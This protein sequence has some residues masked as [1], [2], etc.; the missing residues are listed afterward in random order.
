[1]WWIVS[2]TALI[3]LAIEAAGVTFVLHFWGSSCL[4]LAG[5]SPGQ[6]DL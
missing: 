1:M 2:L 6:K 3:L 4:Q 5:W